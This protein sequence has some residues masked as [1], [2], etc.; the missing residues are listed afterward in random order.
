NTGSLQLS[1]QELRQALHPGPFIDFTDEFS[2]ENKQIQ[3]ILNIKKPDARMRD[4]ELV[5]RYFAYKKFIESYSGNLKVFFDTTVK[6]LNDH[7]VNKQN[8]I[9][10]DAHELEE[11]IKFTYSIWG[12]NAFRKWKNNEYQG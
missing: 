3:K 11:A 2:L 8:D 6:K 7:W 1:P 9:K 12:K 5:V 4:V 10:N